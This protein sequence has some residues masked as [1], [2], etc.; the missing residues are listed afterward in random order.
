M[1]VVLASPEYLPQRH[2]KHRVSQLAVNQYCVSPRPRAEE[3][4]PWCLCGVKKRPSFITR[5]GQ[6]GMCMSL[7]LFKNTQ[8]FPHL[9]KGGNTFVEMLPFVSGRQLNAD[10]G[11]SPRNNREVEADHVDAFFEQLGCHHL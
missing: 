10:P 8:L 2:R 4:V 1:I 6:T 5:L 3:T 7:K 9:G 11:F